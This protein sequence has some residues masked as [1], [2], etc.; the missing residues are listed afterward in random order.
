MDIVLIHPQIP[1]NTGSIARTCAATETPLHIIKPFPFEISEKKAK[2]AGLD[3]WPYVDIAIH[4]SWDEYK[5]I[6][7][8]KNIW[9]FSKFGT[10]LYYEAEF[11]L[12]DALV[13]GSETAGLSEEFIQSLNPQ[14]ILMIPMISP[15]VRSLNLSN[16]VSIALYEARRQLSLDKDV[17]IRERR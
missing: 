15:S 6:R 1:Q 3:Y 4:E 13:F 14:N 12:N 16:A 7:T 17:S 2:R 5:S 8:P 10:R 9:A 11:G